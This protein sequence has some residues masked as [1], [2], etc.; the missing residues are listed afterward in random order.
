MIVWFLS[1]ILNSFLQLLQKSPSN[2]LG[3]GEEGGEEV[4]SHPFFRNINFKRLEAGMVDPPFVPDVSS[5]LPFLTS[6]YWILST[7]FKLENKKIKSE[8]SF[9]FL[10]SMKKVTVYLI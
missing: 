8:D 10:P 7:C 3:C 5:M 1:D 9:K 4:K 2:R 6:H